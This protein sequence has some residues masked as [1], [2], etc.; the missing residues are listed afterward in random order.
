MEHLE[1][2]SGVT[3]HEVQESLDT[4]GVVLKP[5][6]EV[7]DDTLDDNPKVLLLVVLGNLL[8]GVLLVG[9]GESL[10]VL[11]LGGSGGSVLLG[12]LSAGSS[13]STLTAPLDGDLAGLRGIDVESDLTK[14]G[15]TSVALKSLLEEVVAGGV[16]GDTAVDNAAK[17][18]RTTEAVGTVDTTGKLTAGVETLKGLLLLVEDLGLVVDLDTTHGE[19]EDGLHDG[20]VEVVVD[21]DGHVVEE[22]LAPRILLLALSDGVV[23]LEGLLEVL[24]SAADLLGELVAG[25]LLHETT[26]RVV[27]GVEVKGL[28]SLGVEDEADGV[29]ALILLLVDHARDVVTVAELV[30]EAVT[31]AVEEE[32]TLTTKGLSSKELPLGVGVLGVD[33][34]G[35]VDL[36]L[37]HVNAVTANGHD[38]LLTVTSGVGAVGGSKAVDIGAVLLQERILGEIGGITTSGED[39]GAIEGLGLAVDLILDTSNLVALLV[40]AGD[41]SLLD[42]LDTLG[43]GLGE[44]LK[45]LHESIGDG[46]TGELGIVTTVGTGLGV[47]TAGRVSDGILQRRSFHA[48]KKGGTYPR[49]ETRVRSRLKTSW[50]HSTAAADL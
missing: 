47:T 41:A 42:D 5:V 36:N 1:L 39:N 13:L 4:T 33:E 30:A 20:D 21:I 19:V 12:S 18:G 49:R 31:I 23:G 22:L 44:L 15:S 29:L 38:H 28:G 24:R 25:H 27:A 11:L 35:R 16:T 8:H 7:K 14:T 2:L 3:A 50:S 9:D 37:V 43:L 10:G 6:G 48:Q 46:H 40:E 26:A 32:T 17:E 34:T 45:A